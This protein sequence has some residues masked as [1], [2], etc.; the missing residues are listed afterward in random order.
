[1]V[2]YPRR[3]RALAGGTTATEQ[4]LRSVSAVGN[5]LIVVAVL[6][7]SGPLL[8][9]VVARVILLGTVV[10]SFGAALGS[11]ALTFRRVLGFAGADASMP[12]SDPRFACMYIHD[13]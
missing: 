6:L 1:M 12:P 7:M 3:V 4:D 11:S 13:H 10:L 5:G 9:A 2:Q 8:R